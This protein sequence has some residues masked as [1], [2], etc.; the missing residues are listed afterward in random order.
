MSEYG[1][2]LYE[3]QSKVVIKAQ[4]LKFRAWE[5]E[6]FFGRVD[7]QRYPSLSYVNFPKVCTCYNMYFIS[8][9]ACIADNM[10]LQLKANMRQIGPCVHEVSGHNAEHNYIINYFIMWQI[11]QCLDLQ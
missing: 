1:K 11:S 9:Y 2:K 10:N 4:T 5:V 3:L 8:Y 6:A 7:K